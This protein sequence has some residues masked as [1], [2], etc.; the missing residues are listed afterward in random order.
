MGASDSKG[1]TN[2]D[3]TIHT[4][5]EDV[6]VFAVLLGRTHVQRVVTFLTKAS[7]CPAGYP[8]EPSCK[9]DAIGVFTLV[10]ELDSSS[11]L[12]LF[13]SPALVP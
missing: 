11:L 10:A 12:F 13:T 1:P 7:H 4:S 2:D 8:F 6:H 9:T 3:K 5:C